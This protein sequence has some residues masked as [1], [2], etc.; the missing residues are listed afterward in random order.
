MCCHP[1][2]GPNN[3]GDGCTISS[4]SI[5]YADLNW[6]KSWTPPKRLSRRGND[7]TRSTPAAMLGAATSKC[8]GVRNRATLCVAFSSASPHTSSL[9]GG[10]RVLQSRHETGFADFLGPALLYQFSVSFF[11]SSVAVAVRVVGTIVDPFLGHTKRHDAHQHW[12]AGIWLAGGRPPPYRVLW[13][14]AVP[15]I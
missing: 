11:F 6:L 15:A 14:S 3:A 10:L 1:D 13:Q 9:D 4:L 7:A 5:R 8:K 2:G 12:S